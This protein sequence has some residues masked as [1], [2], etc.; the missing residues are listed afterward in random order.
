MTVRTIGGQII[1]FLPHSTLHCA[2]TG[3]K[4]N[5]VTHFFLYKF[6][7]THYGEFDTSV[8]VVGNC[9][10]KGFQAGLFPCEE[11]NT[12]KYSCTKWEQ[13]QA[14]WEKFWV[15]QEIKGILSYNPSNALTHYTHLANPACPG[16]LKSLMTFA[17][18]RFYFI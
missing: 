8:K 5:S 14:V 13:L 1:T 16:K 9:D 6:F 4:L 12:R 18:S 15:S 10:L 17:C 7:S 2:Q 11:I 3:I